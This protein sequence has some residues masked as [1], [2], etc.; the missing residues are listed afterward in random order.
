[1]ADRK[2]S[3]LPVADAPLAGDEQVPIVQDGV[4]KRATVDQLRGVRITVSE[5]P[6]S[7]PQINDL[8]VPVT[9]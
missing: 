9:P 8:W 2:I 6:P 4:T 3:E 7:D 1:M 5:S